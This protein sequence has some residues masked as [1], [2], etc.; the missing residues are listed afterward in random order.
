MATDV[1]KEGREV[2]RVSLNV[3]KKYLGFGGFGLL[4]VVLIPFLGQIVTYVCLNVFMSSWTDSI[5]DDDAYGDKSWFWAYIIA[6]VCQAIAMVTSISAMV[7]YGG[8]AGYY[9]HKYLVKKLLSTK[10][11][12]YDVFVF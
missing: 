10:L 1:E 12:F 4:A 5:N 11:G 9:L 7:L 2:G 6:T 3:F 8:R